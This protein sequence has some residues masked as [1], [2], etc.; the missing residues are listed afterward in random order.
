MRV[1]AGGNI[2]RKAPN[3]CREYSREAR[4]PEPEQ[5]GQLLLGRLQAQGMC[6]RAFRRGPGEAR[7][8]G[9]KCGISHIGT[10]GE[11]PKSGELPAKD[12]RLGQVL[13]FRAS[14]CIGLFA[15]WSFRRTKADSWTSGWLAPR[16]QRTDWSRPVLPRGGAKAGHGSRECDQGCHKQCCVQT[17]DREA[18][19]Q[20]AADRSASSTSRRCAALFQFRAL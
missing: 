16:P 8:G 10:R 12:A 15:H 5:L 1:R 17:L 3:R 14:P 2:R 9:K 19:L 6:P 20:A 13:P 4:N 11:T 18:L 7:G